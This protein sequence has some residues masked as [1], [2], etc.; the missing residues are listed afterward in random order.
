MNSSG[1]LGWF[2]STVLLT[3]PVLADGTKSQSD[4][5]KGAKALFVDSLSGAEIQ[6]AGGASKPAS[7]PV[8]KNPPKK[9]AA[10]MPQRVASTGLMYWVELLKPT[11]EAIRV[12][13]DQ[14]FHSGDRI[15]VHL[16]GS[17]DGA[18]AVYQRDPHG[19][20][21]QLFPDARVNGGSGRVRKGTNTV[22]P[23]ESSWFRFDDQV[24]TERLLIILTPDSHPLP[25]PAPETRVAANDR[26]DREYDQ[27]RPSDGSKG[28][29]LETDTAG[30]EPATYVVRPVVQKEVEPISVEVT[31]RH[32]R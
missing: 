1:A 12:T 29:V 9:T 11:S 26:G 16:T 14:V 32:E 25:S 10:A 19:K 17:V 21:V 27:L 28:L 3:C 13:T 6:A 15:R 20:A 5:E 31:L 18:I 8:R 22:V 7:P 30:T 24:G 2:L 23:S 4:A